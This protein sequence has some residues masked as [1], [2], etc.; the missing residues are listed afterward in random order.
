[1]HYFQDGYL[2]SFVKKDHFKVMKIVFL[3][4]Y[5]KNNLLEFNVK[6]FISIFLHHNKYTQPGDLS[7]A[8]IHI[9]LTLEM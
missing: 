8:S 4:F 3:K 1:M 5:V 7:T 6:M 2:R 9:D